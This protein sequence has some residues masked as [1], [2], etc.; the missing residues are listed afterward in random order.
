M[1]ARQTKQHLSFQTKLLSGFFVLSSLLV[2]FGWK[3]VQ[4]SQKAEEDLRQVVHTHEVRE[5]L[6]LV[7][8]TLTDNRSSVGGY[9]I[10]A[11][12]EFLG[13][14]EVGIKAID[15]QIATLRMLTSDNPF[16]RTKVN[17]LEM[18]VATNLEWEKGVVQTLRTEGRAAAASRVASG[19]GRQQMERIRSLISE[20]S[21]EK[22]RLLHECREKASASASTTRLVLYRSLLIISPLLFITPRMVKP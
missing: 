1:P 10:T 9:V 8:L 22:N 12:P 7:L 4:S 19:I 18:L 5:A 16:Q 3:M 11:N 14:F 17:T 13:P 15:H 20:M 21:N 6:E 2:F